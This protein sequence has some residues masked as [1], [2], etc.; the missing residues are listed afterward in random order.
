MSVV[1]TNFDSIAA[2]L[3]LIFVVAPFVMLCGAVITCVCAYI[4]RRLADS[5]RL[6]RMALPRC[7]QC[8]HYGTTQCPLCG[9]ADPDDF[10][11]RGERRDT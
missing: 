7:S 9:Q 11:S 4:G 5:L 6:H 1:E 3:I 2:A 10:C 8:C